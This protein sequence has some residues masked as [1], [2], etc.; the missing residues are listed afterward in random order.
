[1]LDVE[2]TAADVEKQVRRILSLDDGEDFAAI[3]ARDPV[4]DG[5]IRE[6]P[7]LRP[8]LFASPYEAASWSVLSTRQAARVAARVK[9]RLAQELGDSGAF[10]L[11]QRIAGAD[12]LP[13]VSGERARRLRAVAEAA[14]GGRLDPAELRRLPPDE[15]LGA[16]QRIR[17]IGP[18]FASLI[19]VRGVGAPDYLPLEVPRVRE[20]AMR[21][22]GLTE[23][24]DARF[25]SLAEP[26]R[27]YRS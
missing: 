27:P 21:A 9:Q 26:W 11:P 18:F 10:P 4:I 24:D 23:L 12:E 15:A 22:Y 17:G 2:T 1:M 5:L 8:V 13:G 19:L 25:E 20:A 3:G 7:G 16:L 6:Q 14:L